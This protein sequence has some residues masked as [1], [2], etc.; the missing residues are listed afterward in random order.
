MKKNKADKSQRTIPTFAHT[1]KAISIKEPWATRILKDGKTIET[2]TWKT[3]YRGKLLL[4][5]SR[6]PKS[7]ISGKAYAIAE[8]VDCRPMRK[9][10]ESAAMCKIYPRAYSWMLD[11]VMTIEPFEVLGQLG[12]FSVNVKGKL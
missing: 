10:D 12:L 11:N 5:A 3:A 4:C 9:D 7:D 6:Y 8:L 1:M 2:R